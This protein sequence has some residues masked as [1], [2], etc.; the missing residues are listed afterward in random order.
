MNK[1]LYLTLMFF[2]LLLLQ[3]LILN[4]VLLFGYV[5]PYLYIVFVF[6]YPFN[7]NRFLFLT[8]AF[9]LGLCVDFF[10]NSGGVHAFATLFIAYIRLYFFKRIFQKIENEYN[11][12]NLKQEMFSRVF[13]YTAVLTVIHHFILFC[14]INFSFNNIFGIVVNTLLSSIFTLLLYFM[15]NFI[16]SHKQ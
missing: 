13:N 8:S 10:T 5:N 3:V 2:F 7:K 15:G 14:L 12:F 16:F 6:I 4:N 1:S 11:L 9:L